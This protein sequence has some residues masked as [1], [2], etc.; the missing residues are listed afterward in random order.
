M[1]QA[2]SWAATTRPR[3]RRRSTS[4][5]TVPREGGGGTRGSDADHSFQGHAGKRTNDSGKQR[6]SAPTTRRTRRI[7]VNAL[8]GSV[9]PVHRI[10]PHSLRGTA[11]RPEWRNSMR[12]SF[13]TRTINQI[14]VQGVDAP[15]VRKHHRQRTHGP[16][17]TRKPPTMQKFASS[18]IPC[19]VPG[20]AGH[21]RGVTKDHPQATIVTVGRWALIHNPRYYEGCTTQRPMLLI[22]LTRTVRACLDCWHRFVQVVAHPPVDPK[23]HRECPFLP[24]HPWVKP[25]PVEPTT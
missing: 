15:W 7:Q 5:G 8:G 3:A 14:R 4:C 16:S 24:D 9:R 1:R 19:E 23:F 22:P 11:P 18:V 17:G 6:P 21:A 25:E 13:R 2:P 20:C 12:R 10:P